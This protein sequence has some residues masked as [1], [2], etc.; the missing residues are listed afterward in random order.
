MT[1]SI[2]ETL[3]DEDNSEL[4]DNNQNLMKILNDIQ[5]SQKNVTE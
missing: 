4:K 2:N 3:M 5:E 1:N